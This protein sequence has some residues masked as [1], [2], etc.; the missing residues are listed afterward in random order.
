M[1][2]CTTY[3]V[4]CGEHET[5]ISAH[6]DLACGIPFIEITELE[7]K[8]KVKLRFIDRESVEDL[9]LSLQIVKNEM[10][11]FHSNDQSVS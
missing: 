6:L 9:L 3:T 4:N 7:T 11:R 2:E 10:D 8:D 5:K 1:F